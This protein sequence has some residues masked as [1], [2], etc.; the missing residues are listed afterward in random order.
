MNPD[1]MATQRPPIPSAITVRSG[2]TLIELMIVIA[3]IGIL[4][5][6]A[7]PAYHNY[8]TKAHD[9]ACLSEAKGY[10]SAVY[11]WAADPSSAES[12][13]APD[14]SGASCTLTPESLTAIET[15]DD[16]ASLEGIIIVATPANGS[17]KVVSCALSD[18]ASCDLVAGS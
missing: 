14:Y 8:V 7:I 15:I 9:S 13:P 4:A 16:A 18:G 12:G 2:F 17:G 5:A 3:I 1:A 11:V 10:A 6:I